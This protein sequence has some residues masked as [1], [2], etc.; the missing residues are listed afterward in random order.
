MGKDF[1]K[2]KKNAERTKSGSIDLETKCHL[3]LSSTAGWVLSPFSFNLHVTLSTQEKSKPLLAGG[4][5]VCH[6]PPPALAACCSVLSIPD[7]N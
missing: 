4:V 1:P 5:A 7:D 6:V 2:I 3:Q